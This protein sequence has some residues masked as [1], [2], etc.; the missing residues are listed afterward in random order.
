MQRVQHAGR[1]GNSLQVL[2]ADLIGS[3][4][5]TSAGITAHKPVPVLAL[6][7]QLLAAGLDPDRALEV[8]RGATLA[9]HIRTLAEGARLTVKDDNRG[10]PRFVS[11]RPGPDERGSVACGDAPSM[12][13]SPAAVMDGAL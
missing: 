7:R 5:C 1:A 12:R 4:I 3:N 9:L 13:Q 10:V 8:Y 6:C 2:R 11:Y